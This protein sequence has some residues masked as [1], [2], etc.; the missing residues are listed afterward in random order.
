MTKL[1]KPDKKLIASRRKF[2]AGAA[3]VLAMPAVFRSDEARASFVPGPYELWIDQLGAKGDGSTDDT[4]A[5]S[6]IA[7]YLPNGGTVRLSNGKNYLSSLGF[8]IPEGVT[9][10]GPY[11]QIGLNGLTATNLANF[12]SI[13]LG[14]GSTITL[15]GQGSTITG[16]AIL[17]QGM[18]FPQSS[19]SAWVGTAIS[20]TIGASNSCVENCMI[21]GFNQAILSPGSVGVGTDRFYVRH[22]AIDCINGISISYSYDTCRVDSVHCWPFLTYN[23]GTLTRTGKAYYIANSTDWGQFV[24]C[25]SYGYATG[26]EAFAANSVNF[27][28]CEVDQSATYGFIT[29]GN[30]ADTNYTMCQAAGC[31]H[32]F[33]IS[34]AA[35]G[36]IGASLVGC[37]TWSST[38][39]GISVDASNT[40]PITVTGGFHRNAGAWGINCGSS[41]AGSKMTVTGVVFNG[42]TSGAAA[43]S[44]SGTLTACILNSETVTGFTQSN[45]I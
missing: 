31:G 38:N 41:N 28:G 6:R 42:N 23:T 45:N 39:N 29:D 21:A 26:Y 19:P 13:T 33:Y 10:A 2:I 30:S 18:T 7:G 25:V 34:T 35:T 5:F 12:R 36:D 44:S 3:A 15:G 14:S 1:I 22:S 27:R 20:V 43:T 40:I 16:C 8:T 32:G 11:G 4:T 17:P 9:L 24:N 37:D